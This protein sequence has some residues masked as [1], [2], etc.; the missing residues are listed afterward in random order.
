MGDVTGSLRTLKCELLG[1]GLVRRRWEGG[2]NPKGES[3]FTLLHRRSTGLSQKEGSGMVYCGVVDGTPQASHARQVS[4]VITEFCYYFKHIF[5]G[6]STL[7]VV[8][9][10]IIIFGI[11]IYL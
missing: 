9:M 4:T 2:R 5:A 10:V 6:L 11:F 1:K 8:C 7:D 3:I